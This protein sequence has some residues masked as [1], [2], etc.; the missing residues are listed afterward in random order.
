MGNKKS[1][2]KKPEVSC[3]HL[4]P[5]IKSNKDQIIPS[6]T[7]RND[8]SISSAPT[9]SVTYPAG[10]AFDSTRLRQ[11]IITTSSAYRSHLTHSGEAPQENFTVND[12]VAL[13]Q[14]N[15]I[16]EKKWEPYSVPTYVWDAVNTDNSV[17]NKKGYCFR[18]LDFVLSKNR[19]MSCKL[20]A[21]KTLF[22]EYFAQEKNV[23]ITQ[24]FCR[25]RFQRAEDMSSK[26][27]EDQRIE[28]ILRG[29]IEVDDAGS[30]VEYHFVGCSNSQVRSCSFMFKRGDKKSCSEIIESEFLPDISHQRK[31]NKRV[32]Y[33]GLLFTDCQYIFNLPE[34]TQVEE[35]P[36]VSRNGHTFTDGCGLI[37]LPLAKLIANNIGWKG[38]IPSIIQIRYCGFGFI[39]KG[40]LVTDYG[41]K[42]K[43]I[44]SLRKSLCKAST[45]IK[46][47]EFS[48]GD[49][50]LRNKLG[51]V[52]WSRPKKIGKLNHQVVTLLSANVPTDVLQELQK[53]QLRDIQ[54]SRTN[55]TAASKSAAISR[56]WGTYIDLLNSKSFEHI[57]GPYKTLCESIETL[58]TRKLEI[59]LACSRLLFGACVPEHLEKVL[60]EGEC[61]VLLEQNPYVGEVL[62]CRSPSYAPGDLRILKAINISQDSPIKR[63]KNCILFSSQGDRPDPDKM[64]GGDLDGDEYL[65]VW[66]PALLQFSSQIG[67]ELPQSYEP[68]ETKHETSNDDDLIAYLSR[69][70]DIILGR[71]DSCF[72]KVAG[73]KGIKSIDCKALATIFSRAVDQYPS[74]LKKLEE[75]CEK[76]KCAFSTNLMVWDQM[77]RA[78]FDIADDLKKRK[79]PS[80]EEWLNFFLS[81]TETNICN[82]LDEIDSGFLL[83]KQQQNYHSCL[84]ANVITKSN[85][86]VKRYLPIGL[87]KYKAQ[88]NFKSENAGHLTLN[89]KEN[90]IVMLMEK[91]S[92]SLAELTVPIYE[93]N[94]KVID[95]MQYHSWEPQSQKMVMSFL[96]YLE[97]VI[98]FYRNTLKIFVRKEDFSQDK[99]INTVSPMRPTLDKM[100]IFQTNFEFLIEKPVIAKPTKKDP[101]LAKYLTLLSAIGNDIFQY[102]DEMFSLSNK[103][104]SDMSLFVKTLEQIASTVF[105]S[106]NYIFIEQA[107]NPG[108]AYL[109]NMMKECFDDVLACGSPHVTFLKHFNHIRLLS[110]NKPLPLDHSPYTGEILAFHS[111]R[112]EISNTVFSKSFWIRAEIRIQILNDVSECSS[113]MK[114]RIKKCLPVLSKRQ[115]LFRYLQSSNVVVVVAATGS[116]KSTQVP[117][118][119]A[120]DLSGILGKEP[121]RFPSIV[122]TQPRRLAAKRVAARVAQEYGCEISRWVGYRIG[123]KLAKD[124][125]ECN[126]VS[127]ETRIQFVTEGLLLVTLRR[128]SNANEY[129]CLIIDE[130]H[131]R[132]KDTDLLMAHCKRIVAENTRH[133]LFK[134]IIMSAS[135]DASKFSTY[136]EGAPVLMC[137]GRTFPVKVIYRQSPQG[138]KSVFSSS[139]EYEEMVD[140]AVNV[141]FTEIV[142][143][144]EEG[145]VLIF[146]PGKSDIHSCL[147]KIKKRLGEMN[148]NTLESEIVPSFVE[149]AGY[150]LYAG[151]TTEDQDAATDPIVRSPLDWKTEN[152]SSEI[153]SDDESLDSD[154]RE[155]L[156]IEDEHLITSNRRND[157]AGD[158][159]HLNKRGNLSA[160]ES[161][162]TIDNQSDEHVYTRKIVV[163]TNIAE[164]SL[165][166]EGVKFV[167]D[168]GKAKRVQYDHQLRLSALITQDVSKASA[169]QRMGRAGRIESGTCYRLYSEEHFLHTMPD[170]EEPS[171]KQSPV[172]D[173]ILRSLEISKNIKIIE[174][175]MDPPSVIATET[176]KKRLLNLGFIEYR[177]N[178]EL[179]ITRDGEIALSCPEIELE[180]V[181]M[182]LASR[183]YNCTGRALKLAGLMSIGADLFI[184]GM[185][186][187]DY[188][189]MTSKSGDH[190]T[191]LNVYEKFEKLLISPPRKKKKGKPFSIHDWCEQF[192]IHYD[193]LMDAKRQTNMIYMTLKKSLFSGVTQQGTEEQLMKAVVS[194]Y[195]HNI[196]YFLGQ[197]NRTDGS[198]IITP[199]DIEN[200]ADCD[201]IY[202]QRLID[203]RLLKES[204]LAQQKIILKLG[205]FNKLIKRGKLVFMQ[206]TSRI[207]A[208]WVLE[209]APESWR[210][211]VK[212]KVLEDG[213]LQTLIE[214]KEICG[215]G[216]FIYKRILG[217]KRSSIKR[218]IEE[219]TE[220]KIEVNLID[221]KITCRGLVGNVEM[222]I[223]SLN[224]EI[225]KIRRDATKLPIQF[226]NETRVFDA[227]VE[228]KWDDVEETTVILNSIPIKEH[229]KLKKL[230]EFLPSVHLSRPNNDSKKGTICFNNSGE[231]FFIPCKSLKSAEEIKRHLSKKLPAYL[232]QIRIDGEIKI[233]TRH[234]FIFASL[235]E[236][237]SLATKLGMQL[238]TKN[239]T[240]TFKYI[241]KKTRHRGGRQN[242]SPIE[243]QRLADLFSIPQLS[244][245]PSLFLYDQNSFCCNDKQIYKLVD[246]IRNDVM[247]L[248]G[249][250]IESSQICFNRQYFR[251]ELS[252]A[253]ESRIVV[254]NSI[255]EIMGEIDDQ[256]ITVE[257]IH[258]PQYLLSKFMKELEGL[259]KTHS[260]VAISVEIECEKNLPQYPERHHSMSS[261]VTLK[262]LEQNAI[263]TVNNIVQ[264]ILASSNKRMKKRFFITSDTRIVDCSDLCK[265]ES[266][267]YFNDADE[268]KFCAHCWQKLTITA[269]DRKNDNFIRLSICGCYFCI[270]CL[271]EMISS[272][273]N[274]SK[275]RNVEIMIPR[276][277]GCEEGC[278]IVF[279]D[280]KK[281]GIEL[282]QKF[283]KVSRN[284]YVK[285]C[286]TMAKKWILNCQT[287]DAIIRIPE[288]QLSSATV[289]DDPTSVREPS[290]GGIFKCPKCSK[291]IYCRTC[292]QRL[293]NRWQYVSH[294]C[295]D[296]S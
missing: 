85:K 190:I 271:K 281:V 143:D 257:I 96:E 36:D 132:G 72:F 182:L 150:P 90:E 249:N 41:E 27:Q 34:D 264:D 242:I 159:T 178:R 57:V 201:G 8:E 269:T 280:C 16:V 98:S 243:K 58:S 237:E 43:H 231:H 67:S 268:E 110:L 222:A 94:D 18:D 11:P 64:S 137:E 123:K 214:E 59:P 174:Q 151:M 206:I 22:F 148:R 247:S 161:I 181:R 135:I 81:I 202:K 60:S 154:I 241:A 221:G 113:R 111:F 176:A 279:S 172:D 192:G 256:Q 218:T 19:F 139:F 274:R 199:V 100:S 235:P 227:D 120:D 106:Y 220:T 102:N 203:V 217:N 45:K 66:D 9:S 225:G 258:L 296:I 277:L 54:S 126:K 91:F 42:E 188:G 130:A 103:F 6:A 13:E 216:E 28:E 149:L 97:L 294:G 230:L 295:E 20:S 40:V 262:C 213:T 32:K 65:V 48:K 255:N 26:C 259:R 292:G 168:C 226:S 35:I 245:L 170:Y 153:L 152:S 144:E 89:V 233:N 194:G 158:H 124:P 25:I 229:E 186:E 239:D 211:S 95:A 2:P 286:A 52:G 162:F 283:N 273:L 210:E 71:I 114:F 290:V 173:L 86:N 76:T 240:I 238:V 12:D 112:N 289:Q 284:L 109:L 195:F 56:K 166:V 146:L 142:K 282:E 185:A 63:L 179:Q 47:E 191:I 265:T 272:Q 80:K 260:A 30:I 248:P 198:F 254:L 29:G 73:S 288:Q 200:D 267:D 187:I 74:D 3:R 228:S 39:C 104:S 278:K 234:A 156:A 14:L 205:I 177:E 287:C 33:S 108:N 49:L 131:E 140:H 219:Q 4:L 88:R 107:M 7:L 50:V 207:D 261:K 250:K 270:P 236:M 212:F 275:D 17:A 183:E 38:D 105:R 246:R 37:S 251:F 46:R 138:D 263:E 87:Q 193:M 253:P 122:C 127:S 180:S 51:I 70:D 197:N 134:V 215:I 293:Y 44:I 125:K 285:K 129:D 145:D 117:Q 208:Q 31:I 62:V 128:V 184:N 244:L 141:L 136:F 84:I 15:I 291:T 163:C 223:Q 209:C 266:A 189:E 224:R 93:Q 101:R 55:V 5:D 171:I 68:P 99:D 10:G 82:A 276:C 164:T 21:S 165:T 119:L 204:V 155:T 79:D 175:L 53:V 169:T 252:G 115:Q 133:N 160:L 24:D 118:Y 1:V 78:Q 167:I 196:S 92:Q 23:N 83:S 61:I 147:K 232:K 77:K 157:H 116:G 75:L 121:G 69:Y